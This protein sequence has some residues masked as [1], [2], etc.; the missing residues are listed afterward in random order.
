M[1]SASSDSPWLKSKAL[2]GSISN[3]ERAR[4]NELQNPDMD[5][6]LA[7]HWR[8]RPS[9]VFFKYLRLRVRF[10]REASRAP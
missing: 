7:P 6:P 4:V 1:V 10:S 3:V 5:K 8:V 2:M 9:N